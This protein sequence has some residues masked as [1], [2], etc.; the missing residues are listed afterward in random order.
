M[1]SSAQ[2]GDATKDEMELALANAEVEGPLRSAILD[3]DV[4]QLQV[5]LQQKPLVGF[6]SPAEEPN[7]EDEEKEG[8]DEPS[9]KE[10]RRSLVCSSASNS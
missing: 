2:W 4:A 8:E 1:G 5:L 3:K 9:E 10:A 6:I 7:E